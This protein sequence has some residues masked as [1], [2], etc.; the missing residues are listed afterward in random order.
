MQKKQ[1]RAKKGTFKR[2]LGLVFRLNKVSI[3]LVVLFMLIAT[4][5]NVGGM[6]MVQNVLAEAGNMVETG[7]TDFSQI[8]IYIGIMIAF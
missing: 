3:I 4:F 5:A 8:I 6:S 1:L 7:S 2:L